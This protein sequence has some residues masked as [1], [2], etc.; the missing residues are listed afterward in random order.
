MKFYKQKETKFDHDQSFR[1]PISYIT[2]NIE[3][4]IPRG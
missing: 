3:F 4:G 2:K 1:T